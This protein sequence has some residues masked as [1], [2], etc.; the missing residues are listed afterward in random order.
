MCFGSL[1][2]QDTL[3]GPHGGKLKTLRY[4]KIELVEC[5]QY[6]EVYIY[7]HELCPIN[8]YGLEGRIEFCYE[9]S[10][11]MSARLYPYGYDGFSANIDEQCYDYCTVI[12]K[13]PGES[14]REKFDNFCA[15]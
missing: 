4:Y 14:I 3:Q 2:A 9:N 12:I 7:D 5:Y 13:V 1:R 11:C 6:A 10:K 8:N 15:E